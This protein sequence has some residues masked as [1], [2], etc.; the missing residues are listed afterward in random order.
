MDTPTSC[1]S[2]VNRGEPTAR[3]R[4]YESYGLILDDECNI[5]A[6]NAGQDEGKTE[7]PMTVQLVLD[8]MT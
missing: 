2:D 1:H 3:T 7:G 4:K 6:N 5:L 8:V